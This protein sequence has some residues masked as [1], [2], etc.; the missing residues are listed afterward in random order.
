MGINCDWISTDTKKEIDIKQKSVVPCLLP[1]PT[2]RG[3]RI[4]CLCRER[5]NA[6]AH[7]KYVSMR[8]GPIPNE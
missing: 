7:A 2:S 8:G 1:V 3:L 5:N 4:A 6:E